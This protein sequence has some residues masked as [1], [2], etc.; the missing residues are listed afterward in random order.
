MLELVTDFKALGL[1][2]MASALKSVTSSSMAH[3]LGLAQP[4][5]ALQIGL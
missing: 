4:V 5:V 3:L 1:H 2:G